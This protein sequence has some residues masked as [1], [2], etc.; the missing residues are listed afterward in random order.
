MATIRKLPSG[1]HNVQV[2]REGQAPLSATF[3][4][5][6]EA[7]AWARKIEGD[8]DTGKHFGH[9]R[10]KTLADAIEAFT[11]IKATIKTAE[12][13]NRHLEWWREHYGDR[14]LFHFTSDIVDD[15]ARN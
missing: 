14:K 13:R 9:S 15:A 2:R 5:V 7:K 3:R 4:T 10:V 11:S 12:D 8:I 1:K 6:T